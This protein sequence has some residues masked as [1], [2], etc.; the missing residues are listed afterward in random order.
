MKEWTQQ[1]A[2]D[3]QNLKF[4]IILP[5]ALRQCQLRLRR[6]GRVGHPTDRV[7]ASVDH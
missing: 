2:Q 6:Q 4:I 1:N 7:A 3:N 5:L